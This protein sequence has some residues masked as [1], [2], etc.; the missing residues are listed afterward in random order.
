MPYDERSQRFGPDDFTL[1]PDAQR[2]TCPN[3]QV[4]DKAY[5]TQSGQG[6][7]FRFS[8]EQCQGCSLADKCRSDKL[9]AHHMRQVFISDHRSVL[10]LA[11]TY[12]QTA[13]FRAD[14]KLRALIERIIANLVRYHG[15][16]YARRRGRSNGDYQAKPVL[17]LTKE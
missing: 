16:R 2:L 6:R 7:S 13:D 11:R 5:R 10:A 15:G 14:L 9:P 3:H 17:S 4:S 12:A 1:S 8:A